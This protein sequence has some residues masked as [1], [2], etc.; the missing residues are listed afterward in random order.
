MSH[1]TPT[2]VI[3]PKEKTIQKIVIYEKKTKCINNASIIFMF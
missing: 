1:S 3:F 2:F